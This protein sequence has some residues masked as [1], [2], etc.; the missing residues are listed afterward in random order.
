MSTMELRSTKKRDKG[1]GVEGD[2]GIGEE[3][4]NIMDMKVQRN[5]I[6]EGANALLE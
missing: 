4:Q 6:T 2:W 5:D 1:S 3:G